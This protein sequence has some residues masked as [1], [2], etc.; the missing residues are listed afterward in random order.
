MG[1]RGATLLMTAAVCDN[2]DA[3]N[4]LWTRRDLHLNVGD[5][6]RNTA[7]HH[8]AERNNTAVA[9][10]LLR[11][12]A[13]SE[14]LYA[15]GYGAVHLAILNNQASHEGHSYV[16]SLSHNLPQ[17]EMLAVFVMA[18]KINLEVPSKDGLVPLSLCILQNHVR[19]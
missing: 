14:I 12:G 19:T 15:Q 16:L 13:S 4:I 9:R 5:G 10:C 18:P 3:V 17:L 6:Q 1:S 11:L 2:V 7:L 8:A